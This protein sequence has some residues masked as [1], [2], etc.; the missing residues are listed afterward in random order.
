MTKFETDFW[1]F[2]GAIFSTVEEFLALMFEPPFAT[3]QF[4]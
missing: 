2:H 3:I 1:E 4:S